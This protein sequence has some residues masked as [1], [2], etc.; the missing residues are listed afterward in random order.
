M[1]IIELNLFYCYHIK[2]AFDIQL[3]PLKER[4]SPRRKF[5]KRSKKHY[6]YTNCYIPHSLPTLTSIFLFLN[7]AGKQ[8]YY[9]DKFVLSRF[10]TQKL[11]G[12]PI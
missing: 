8:M 2:K 5:E 6:I 3:K 7:M 4:L 9:D 1:K 12:I 10:F 11:Y